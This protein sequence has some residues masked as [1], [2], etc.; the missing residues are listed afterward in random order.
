MKSPTQLLK[1]I[2]HAFTG[3][4]TALKDETSLKIQLTLGLAAVF[5]GFYFNISSTEWMAV[6]ICIA[7]VLS[8]ETMNS[9]VENLADRITKE[10]DPY[11]KKAKDM[12]AGAV[13]VV[14]TASIIIAFIIFIPKFIA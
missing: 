3:F 7:A 8:A 6:V 2:G 14:A 5:F 12:G 11:I 10:Q 1:S 4:F 9:A 13:L